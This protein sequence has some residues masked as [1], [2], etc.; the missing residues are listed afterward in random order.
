MYQKAKTPSIIL[1]ILLCLG[2]FFLFRAAFAFRGEIG[3]F[4][5]EQFQMSILETQAPAI[6]YVGETE[7]SIDFDKL[8]KNL[9]LKVIPVYGYAKGYPQ[10]AM[11]NQD[12]ELM[13]Q[14]ILSEGRDEIPV[15]TGDVDI[16]SNDNTSDMSGNGII[17]ERNGVGDNVGISETQTVSPSLSETTQ[18]SE[19]N[20]QNPL[21]LTNID[22]AEA[23]PLTELTDFEKL[24]SKYYVM[25]ST[26]TIDP[27]QLNIQNLLSYDMK[28]QRKSDLPQILIYHTHSQE[29]FVDSNFS[30]PSTTI[31]GAGELLAQ[32]LR[33]YG[34][35]VIHDTG[36]Y[37][38]ANRD[39]A[40][41]CAAP[42]LEN[43]LK[44]N[45]SIEVVID[46]HRD[47][48]AEGTHMVTEQNGKTMAQF[49]FF[50]GLSR[51]VARGDI[52]YLKNENIGENLAFSFQAQRVANAYYPGLA[53][54]IY[55]KGYRYNMHYKGKSLLVELGAQTN[56]VEEIMN[57]VEP[58]AH[59]IRL[60]LEGKGAE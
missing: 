59:I 52:D 1:G 36:T 53:R 12:Q 34:F 41:S 16:V 56:T 29:G 3:N 55:L 51:T 43:I 40:Y 25:D 33:N 21:Q 54:K 37:D 10:T 35:N 32:Y 5:F 24:K 19:M 26:T 30:D 13:H 18:I 38:L 49:M 44:E 48:V 9:V 57:A 27:G 46:L 47:G 20:T 39:Y 42:A 7:K 8:G 17:A 6:L 28:I 58:L 14:L 50:N 31:V 15:T 4:F 23:Q 45:P 2:F 22:M 11:E 60:T